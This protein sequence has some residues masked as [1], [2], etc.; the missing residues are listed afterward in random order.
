MTLPPV[1]GLAGPNGTKAT[2]NTADTSHPRCHLACVQAARSALILTSLA[3]PEAVSVVQEERPLS[4]CLA[5][6]VLLLQKAKSHG[7]MSCRQLGRAVIPQ[8]TVR[9]AASSQS[10]RELQDGQQHQPGRTGD[11]DCTSI[12]PYPSPFNFVRGAY[13]II[14]SINN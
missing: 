3:I 2:L 11:L 1:R 8:V 9:P 10:E 13:Q 5:L 12:S 7:S 14:F 6:L 4:C